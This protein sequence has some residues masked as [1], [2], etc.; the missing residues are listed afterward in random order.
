[1]LVACWGLFLA[2]VVLLHQHEE[3]AGGDNSQ[4]KQRKPEVEGIAIHAV[5]RTFDRQQIVDLDHDQ[6]NLVSAASRPCRASV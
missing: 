2:Q 4:P 5:Q 3:D 1:M 6:F